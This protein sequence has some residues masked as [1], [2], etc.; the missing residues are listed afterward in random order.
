[1]PHAADAFAVVDGTSGEVI[2]K[3]DDSYTD[4]GGAYVRYLAVA[5]GV[6]AVNPLV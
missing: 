6:G 2:G 5:T 3:V 4:T 1:V